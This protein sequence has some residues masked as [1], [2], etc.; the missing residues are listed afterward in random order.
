VCLAG[1]LQHTDDFRRAQ[2]GGVRI[3]V[4]RAHRDGAAR[5]YFRDGLADRSQH[6]IAPHQ[7]DITHVHLQAHAVRNAIHS[8]RKT[9]Q[10]PV[11]ATVRRLPLL[12]PRTRW[13]ARFRRGQKS[14]A[15]DPAKNRSGV[16]PSPDPDAQARRRGDGCHH[17]N[18]NLLFSRSGP[19][20][21]CNSTKAE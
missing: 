3:T 12:L 13:P 21:I 6:V 8:S 10:T 2:R 4:S 1:A 7:V 15:A 11:V 14:V 17:A 20:S 16:A 18:F 5:G 19:C 9:S